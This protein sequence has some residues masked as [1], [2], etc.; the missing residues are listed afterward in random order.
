MTSTHSPQ[1]PL[2]APDPSR[3]PPGKRPLLTTGDD[4]DDENRRKDPKITRAC[5]TCK[6]KKVRCDGTLPCRNCAKRKLHCFYNAKYNRGR[7]PTPPPSM[8]ISEHQARRQSYPPEQNPNRQNTE[9]V[10]HLVPESQNNPRDSP[11]VELE[12]QY[13]DPTS[14]LNFLHRAWKKLSTQNDDSALY[15]LNN[16]GR[17]QLLTS[18][19]DPPFHVDDAALDD[20]IPVASAAREL[21]EFYFETCVVTYRMFHRQLVEGWMEILLKNRQERRPITHSLGNS[22]TAILLTIMAIASLRR[23]KVNGKGP[24]DDNMNALCR[25]DRL[26][27]AGMKLTETEMG[28]PKVESVQARLIQVLY[29]LQ[30]ARMNKAWYVFGN[31]FQVTLSLGMHR[32]RDQRRNFPFPGRP[33]NYIIS[34]CYKRTFWVA[35]IVDTYLS[36]VFGR[37][38]LYQDENIDQDFPSMVN[39]EDMKPQGPC[40]S[41]NPGDCY[42]DALI[43]H[44]KIAQIIG[45]ISREVYSISNLPNEDRLAAVQRLCHDLHVWW[46]SLPPHLGTVKPSTLIS[47]FRRQAIAMRLAYYHALMHA[48]RPFLLSEGAYEEV[49]ECITAARNSLELL[50]RMAKDSTLFHSF[51]WTYYVIF[52]ALSVVYVWE[53][54]RTTRCIYGNDDQTSSKLFDLAEECHGHL[55]RAS[56]SLSQNQRYSII[57]DELRSEAQRCRAA[58]ESL[59]SQ[60]PDTIHGAEGHVADISLSFPQDPESCLNTAFLQEGAMPGVLENLQFSDW[61]MLDSSA[62]LPLSDSNYVSPTDLPGVQ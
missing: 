62:F 42:I 14:G 32:C 48:N 1:G 5:D 46:A 38:R 34:E 59:Q 37:P 43:H 27:S 7:P 58:M 12:G 41:D 54:Q 4:A 53:I 36:V 23:D 10:T 50:N 45:K 29:L 19:G 17:D 2:L 47:S 6:R 56:T 33:H 60:R 13:S 20:V 16:A 28:F 61:Q 15:H 26:F 55:K 18:A 11:E 51:W 39:D 25:S 52:C 35:Y 44:A 21:Q 31:A 9:P 8:T 57:L 3:A 30:T 40:N 24:Q 49:K 22:R